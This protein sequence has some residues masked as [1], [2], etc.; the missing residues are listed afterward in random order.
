[1]WDKAE[2]LLNTDRAITP[3]PGTATS[4]KMVLSYSSSIPHMVTKASNGQ[5]KCDSSCL[6]WTSSEICSHT[7]AVSC[8]NGDLIAFLQW[9]NSL[10]KQPS[11]T[12]L[13]MSGLPSGRGRKGSVPKRSQLIS[14]QQP[15][16][17]EQD[18]CICAHPL[19]LLTLLWLLS[20]MPPLCQ[21]L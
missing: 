1:M 12:T 9:Y 3:A 21:F 15:T 13:S 18:H 20:I 2:D 5:Y 7:L 17:G 11:I 8:H 19:C 6:S 14:T 4:A 16:L 10:S